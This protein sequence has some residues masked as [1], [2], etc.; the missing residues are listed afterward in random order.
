MI[1]ML[2]RPDTWVVSAQRHADPASTLEPTAPLHRRLCSLCTAHWQA[3]LVAYD[4]ERSQG[5]AAGQAGSSTGALCIH[6]CEKM[7]LA[8]A[9]VASHSH[10]HP[11]EIAD[12]AVARH[13]VDEHVQARQAE[14]HAHSKSSELGYSC[15][16]TCQPHT[17]L[18]GAVAW[19]PPSCVDL[20]HTPCVAARGP[21]H[22][23]SGAPGFPG[24]SSIL[25]FARC[26]GVEQVRRLL[27]AAGAGRR[28]A[29]ELLMLLVR[30]QCIT[31]AWMPCN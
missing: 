2:C 23:G 3:L 16:P 14:P 26:G 4:L 31:Q 17:L 11:A 1:R 13:V 18:H 7:G 27:T 28:D 19:C 25:L 12:W 20:P 24:G 15:R 21:G 10:R 29:G 8:L 6:R 5:E 30:Q 22:R 9:L